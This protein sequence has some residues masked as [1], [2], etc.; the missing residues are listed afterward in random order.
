MTRVV[1]AFL[2]DCEGRVLL[3]QRPNSKSYGGLWEFP[4]G[5]IEDNE[6]P[7]EATVRELEEELAVVVTPLIVHPAYEFLNDVG[8][9]IEFFPITCS[10]EFQSLTLHEHQRAE[11]VDVREV[12]SWNLAPP[13]YDALKY[14]NLWG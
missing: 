4:G 6:S 3:A 14:L 8:L 7:E 11:F 12:S 9:T 2:Y 13:D 1:L 10:W 5:K